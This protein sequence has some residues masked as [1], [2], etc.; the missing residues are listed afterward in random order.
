MLLPFT[1]KITHGIQP[2][3]NKQH[4]NKPIIGKLLKIKGSTLMVLTRGSLVS[5]QPTTLISWYRTLV[6]FQKVSPLSRHSES[7]YLNT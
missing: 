6:D 7:K 3:R 5:T 1:K 4:K 2:R